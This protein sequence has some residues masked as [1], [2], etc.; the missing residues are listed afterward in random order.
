MLVAQSLKNPLRRM[1][2]FHRR[3]PAATKPPL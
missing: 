1:P 3:R 2:L